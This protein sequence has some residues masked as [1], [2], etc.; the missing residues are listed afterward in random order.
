MD[1]Q[2]H[3]QSKDEGKRDMDGEGGHELLLGWLPA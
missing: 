1:K 3:K 2:E